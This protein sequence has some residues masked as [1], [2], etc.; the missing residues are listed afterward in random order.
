MSHVFKLARPTS[1]QLQDVKQLVNNSRL[2]SKLSLYTFNS[3]DELF[4]ADIPL[5]ARNLANSLDLSELGRRYMKTR[6]EAK[7]GEQRKVDTKQDKQREVQ[8][9][10]SIIS[11][12]KIPSYK[13]ANKRGQELF[14]ITRQSVKTAMKS[15]RNYVQIEQDDFYK[16]PEKNPIFRV[17][18]DGQ[19]KLIDSFVKA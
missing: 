17:Y 7:T 19:S 14:E 6:Q 5:S 12:Y 8:K 1:L 4:I 11:P 16:V 3:P 13:R 10:N 2:D 15:F 18:S 9:M